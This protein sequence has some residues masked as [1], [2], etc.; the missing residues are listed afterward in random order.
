MRTI[1]TTIVLAITMLY[2][3]QAQQESVWKSHGDWI[4]EETLGAAET[5]SYAN[6]V[7]TLIS[8]SGTSK[9]S[10]SVRNYYTDN[11]DNIKI[12]FTL[13]DSGF[14]YDSTPEKRNY[15]TVFVISDSDRSTKFE[16]KGVVINEEG[17]VD[18][19]GDN[20]LKLHDALKTS[21][22][23]HIKAKSQVY[24][25]SAVG[26][27]AVKTMIY[28]ALKNH[29]VTNPFNEKDDNPFKG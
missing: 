9:P 3:G 21:K 12:K 27:S 7:G 6:T 2:T 26:Y 19:Y 23:V 4:G 10:L 28:N 25:F 16:L 17:S 14:A 1:I 18:L 29:N 24:K 20:L 8:G 22:V 15:L 11:D 5:T 13:G